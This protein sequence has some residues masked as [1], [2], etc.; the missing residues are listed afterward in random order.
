MAEIKCPN[1]G[2]IISLEQSDVESVIAQVRDEEF[3]REVA[4]R[5]A[6]IKQ[7]NAQE[8]KLAQARA[9]SDLEAARSQAAAELAAVRAESDK[10]IAAL[11]ERLAAQTEAQQREVESAVAQKDAQIAALTAQMDAQRESLS[12]QQKIAVADAVRTAEKERDELQSK[13][14]I[15]ESEARAREAALKEQLQEQARTNDALILAKDQEIVRLKDMKA[16]LSTK[17]LGETLEQHCENEFNA[18]RATAYP[19]AYFEKDSEV[20]GGSKGDYIFR[21]ADEDGTE[22]ISIMFEMKNEDDESASRKKRN[23]DHFAKLDRDRTNKHCEYAVLVSLL[24]PDSELYNRGI[25]DVSYRY[26][27][28]YVVRPQFFLAIISLLRAGALNA[29]EYRREMTLMQQQN[30]DITHFEEDLETFKEGF[31]RN[32]K[33]ASDRYDDA[34]AGIDKTIKLLEKIRDNLTKSE[35]HLVAA[36]NKLDD[37]TVKKLTR[38]NPTMRDKFE[39]LEASRPE[40][41]TEPDT[42]AEDAVENIDD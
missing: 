36:N 7:A 14:A 16:R 5:E 34:I 32:F 42:E 6:L 26:P 24:E 31:F 35:K 39:E 3:A 21:E 11:K 10:E 28:M 18:I 37:L 2:T 19:N 33:Q 13:L 8:V 4:K 38:N 25:V 40:K 12:A 20:I 27:K 23:E 29:L 41:L 9:A 1:C 17:M 15:G 30:I 22:F